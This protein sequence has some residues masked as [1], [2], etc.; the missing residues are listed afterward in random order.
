MAEVNGI[1]GYV[2][3]GA[4]GSTP[5][6][7]LANVGNLTLNNG[8]VETDVTTKQSGFTLTGVVRHEFSCD[9]D[10]LYVPAD[11]GFAALHT[12]YKTKAPI[13]LLILDGPKA[14]AGS[15]GIDADFVVTNFAQVQDNSDKM[16]YNVTV[17]PAKSSRAPQWVTM[18]GS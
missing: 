13:A 10:L 6:T 4:S 1:D 8:V 11:A 2:Y 15:I 14:T 17:K 3:H 7:L 9:F 18:A 5:T 16:R 12:A